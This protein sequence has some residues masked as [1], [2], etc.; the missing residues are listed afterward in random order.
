MIKIFQKEKEVF[1]KREIGKGVR[2]WGC[3]SSKGVGASSSSIQPSPS[4]S[5]SEITQV[6]LNKE[7]DCL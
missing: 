5:I 3:G 1:L 4:T 6:T 7:V 2:V